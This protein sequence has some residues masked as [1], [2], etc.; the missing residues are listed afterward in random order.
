[1][2]AALS[3]DGYASASPASMLDEIPAS[4][5]TRSMLRLG[6]L[7]CVLATWRSVM[8][9]RSLSLRRIVP[10]THVAGSCARRGRLFRYG[11]RAV[12]WRLAM[13]I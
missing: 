13:A 9:R 5:T 7:C 12:S 1:M 4:Q 3:P 2:R 8:S 6:S 11:W 10:T